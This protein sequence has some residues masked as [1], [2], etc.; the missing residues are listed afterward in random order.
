MKPQDVQLTRHTD[1]IAV[2]FGDHQPPLQLVHAN[3]AG[4][5]RHGSEHGIL[6]VGFNSQYHRAVMLSLS[7]AQR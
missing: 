6:N 5:W 3:P 2:R 1:A 7:E 4:P